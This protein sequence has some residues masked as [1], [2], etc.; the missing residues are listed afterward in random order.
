VAEH[1]GAGEQERD[2]RDER[3][4]ETAHP[5]Q[6]QPATGCLSQELSGVFPHLSRIG[7]AAK[8][9][10]ATGG[11]GWKYRLLVWTTGGDSRLQKDVRR[12]AFLGGRPR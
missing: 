9:M 3:E 4:K 5:E 10:S 12:T 7:K 11:F 6:Q 8:I 1:S 2:A